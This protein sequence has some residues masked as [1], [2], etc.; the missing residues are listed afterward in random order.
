MLLVDTALARRAA[1]DRPIQVGLVGAGYMA[2][3]LTLHVSRNLPGMRIAAIA[4]RT[5]DHAADAYRQAG[6]D[7]PQRVQSS[8]QLEQAI[9]RRQPAICDDPQWLCEAESIDAIVEATGTI[10]PA[11]ALALAAIDH[12]KHLILMNAEL[13]ALIGPLLKRRADRAGVVV[14]N[15]DGDQPGVIMNLLRW[16][17]SIGFEPRLAGNIKG[18]QDHHRT[19]TTQRDFAERHR[20]GVKMITSFADGTK[21]AMEMAVVANATGFKVAT[22]GMQG[23]TAQH[24]TEAPARFS[25]AQLAQGSVDY[26]LG[27]EPGPGVFVIGYSDEPILQQYSH[28]LKL[29]NGPYY[30]FYVPYHLPHLEAPLTVA[31]AV[32]F[33]DAAVTPRGAPV[34]E[35]ITYAKRHLQ[36]GER[37]DG[38]GGY[39]I[40][41]V[42]E[43]RATCRHERL[44]PMALAEG[45]RLRRPIECDQSIRFDDVMIPPQ[46]LTDRLWAEQ[47]ALFKGDE[48]VT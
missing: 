40:Y 20:Q 41:G 45:C 15:V 13:D 33:G 26:L 31:R 22:R 44:L 3:G 2:R 48:D 6:F 32:L 8:A 38:I 43:N 36:A 1:A 10:E 34:V 16:V 18:L 4:N 46:R 7:A 21:I 42:A 11:A 5:L 25:S 39:T 19:P 9:A 17:R 47:Q 27:A 37:L 24:V 35:V 14:S 29:G 12:G 28:Y 30:T 23:P